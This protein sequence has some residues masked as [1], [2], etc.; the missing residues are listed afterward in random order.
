MN[1]RESAKSVD[2]WIVANGGVQVACARR[3]P[4]GV[5]VRPAS[6]TLRVL[7]LPAPGGGGGLRW[8]VVE[9]GE[10]GGSFFVEGGVGGAGD[11]D[12]G[13]DVDHVFEGFVE[14][15][16]VFFVEGEGAGSTAVG[17]VE[18]GRRRCLR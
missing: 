3:P 2:G 10:M 15:A 16:F 11:Q 8:L 18:G 6:L 9:E 7:L 17:E 4:L 1:L 5:D 12:D 14:R 13:G